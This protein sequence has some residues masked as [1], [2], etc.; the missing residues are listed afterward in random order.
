MFAAH[1]GGGEHLLSATATVPEG[2]APPPCVALTWH[3]QSELEEHI[4]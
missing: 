2:Q 1:E 3:Q 4:S